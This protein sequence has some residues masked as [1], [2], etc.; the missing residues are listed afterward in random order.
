[1]WRLSGDLLSLFP[2]CPRGPRDQ[3]LP[4]CAHLEEWKVA[5][6]NCGQGL[7]ERLEIIP[8]LPP[9]PPRTLDLVP[10]AKPVGS[11]VLAQAG[12]AGLCYGAQV[13]GKVLRDQAKLGSPTAESAAHLPPR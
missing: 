8:C 5:G 4:H 9:T 13:S 1:M 10:T 3:F 2:V 6:G 12:A 11:P 7:E